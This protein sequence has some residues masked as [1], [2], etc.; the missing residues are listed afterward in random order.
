MIIGWFV[1][2]KRYIMK[3]LLVGASGTIGSAIVKE[4][5]KDTDILSASLNSGNYKV[6]LS[7]LNSIIKL[8][9]NID[10]LD[11]IVCAASRGV[12]FK[13]LLEMTLDDY[14]ASI[15]QKLLGQLSLALEGG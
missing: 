9:E 8:L 3:I 7:D 11:G 4:L 15:Q 12:V 2:K 6:D 13:P 5:K 1:L 14:V 10:D